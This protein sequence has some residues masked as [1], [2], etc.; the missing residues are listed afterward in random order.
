MEK[1]KKWGP[2][3]SN[4]IVTFQISAI[5]HWTMIMRERVDEFDENDDVSQWF[6][7][8][9][10]SEWCVFN[11]DRVAGKRLFFGGFCL[12]SDI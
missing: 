11:S 8:I 6:L 2:S 10:I 1:W 4:Y 9:F 5:F 3:N 7:K 12:F